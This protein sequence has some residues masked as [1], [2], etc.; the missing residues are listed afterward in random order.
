[1]TSRDGDVHGGHRIE[2]LRLR[3]QREDE[4]AAALAGLALAAQEVGGRGRALR[5]G[6]RRPGA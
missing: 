2:G 3:V 4:P 5:E 6:G 1:M